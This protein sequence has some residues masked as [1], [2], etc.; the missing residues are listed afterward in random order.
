MNTLGERINELQARVDSGR[1]TGAEKQELDR[2]IKKYIELDDQREKEKEYERMTRSLKVTV[3]E[4]QVLV[5]LVSDEVSA[6]FIAGD[7]EKTEKL[8]NLKRRLKDLIVKE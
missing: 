6:K 3:A 8:N 2:L 4:L 1:F 5:Q 7:K